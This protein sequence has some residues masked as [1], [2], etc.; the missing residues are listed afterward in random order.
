MNLSNAACILAYRG[1]VERDWSGG[2]PERGQSG[3]SSDRRHQH[4]WPGSPLCCRH[5]FSQPFRSSPWFSTSRQA[6]LKW[7][8]QSRTN[9]GPV[10]R[11][12]HVLAPLWGTQQHTRM[13]CPEMFVSGCNPDLPNHS[14]VHFSLGIEACVSQETCIILPQFD[15]VFDTGRCPQRSVFQR[16]VLISHAHLDHIGGLAHHICTR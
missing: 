12:N 6:S 8:S 13:L 7:T 10:Q 3:R 1:H 5:F 16:H 14:H 9:G 11:G 2:D 4:C 15:V